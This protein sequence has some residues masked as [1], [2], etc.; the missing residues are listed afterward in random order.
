MGQTKGYVNHPQLIRFNECI[1]PVATLDIY[2]TVV[3]Q[4]AEKRGYKFNRSKITAKEPTEP[5]L[6]LTSGQLKYEFDHLL[7]KL[8][9]RD[10]DRFEQIKVSYP[11]VHPLF[12]VVD[13]GIEKWER[14]R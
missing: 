14:V 3:C 4:E 8:R 13:G 7:S 11:L 1:D 10:Q 9:L 5:L 12:S 2:L 6:L